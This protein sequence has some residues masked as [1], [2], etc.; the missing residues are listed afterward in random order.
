M[1]LSNRPNRNI[2]S[3]ITFIAPSGENHARMA[4]SATTTTA[5]SP[6][7]MAFREAESLAEMAAILRSSGRYCVQRRALF[8]DRDRGAELYKSRD[9][10]V[11]RYSRHDDT[12]FGSA[13]GSVTTS[14]LASPRKNTSCMC[15]IGLQSSFHLPL[16]SRNGCFNAN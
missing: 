1:D 10:H 8:P 7:L 3:P 11:F 9:G 2:I 15:A 6:I 12:A 5:S 14:N 4:R 16:Y 13:P